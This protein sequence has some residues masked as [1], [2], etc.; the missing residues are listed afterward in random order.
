MWFCKKKKEEPIKLNY[1]I[2]EKEIDAP[3]GEILVNISFKDNGYDQVK[4]EVE[5][6]TC[7][8]GLYSLIDGKLRSYSER[9]TETTAYVHGLVSPIELGEN[10]I[11]RYIEKF[12]LRNRSLE[13]TDSTGNKICVNSDDVRKITISKVYLTNKTKKMVINQIEKI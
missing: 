12:S 4:V 11:F 13:Y 10:Y 2:V 3:V 5:S 1:K 6:T 8:I 9:H 7:S